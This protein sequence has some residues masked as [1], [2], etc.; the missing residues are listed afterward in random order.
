MITNIDEDQVKQ[1]KTPEM[2]SLVWQFHRLVQIDDFVRDEL[3]NN[4]DQPIENIIKWYR[5]RGILFLTLI[6]GL[7]NSNQAEFRISK[8]SISPTLHQLQARIFCL[9]FYQS[10]VI[11]KIF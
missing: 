10:S 2:Q 7:Q 1:Q 3:K 11:L 5:S 9:E 6:E 4:L 8:T